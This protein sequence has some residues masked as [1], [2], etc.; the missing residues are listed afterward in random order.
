W[1]SVVCTAR[2]NNTCDVSAKPAPARRCH[3]RP[4]ASWTMGNWSK[5]SR[6]CGNGVRVRDVQC[7]DTRDKRILRPFH[8]QSPV[9]KPRVQMVCHEQKCMEWY[10]SSW[11]E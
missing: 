6:S 5:C 8:C 4:C 2:G 7:V 10:V 1:R 11:R 3:L 9:Y